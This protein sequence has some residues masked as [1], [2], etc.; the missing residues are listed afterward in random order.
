MTPKRMQVRVFE[1]DRGQIYRWTDFFERTIEPHRWLVTSGRKE[2]V[3]RSLA[4]AKKV[5]GKKGRI[6]PLYR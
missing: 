3:Y 1:L 6:T 2:S 4:A 5:A